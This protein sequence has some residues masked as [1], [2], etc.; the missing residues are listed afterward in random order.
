MPI[1]LKTCRLVL[2]SA[3][4]LS[5][6][7]TSVAQGGSEQTWLKP[8]PTRLRARLVTRLE[9]YVEYERERKYEQLYELFD[10]STLKSFGAKTKNDYGKSRLESDHILN[11][12]PRSVTCDTIR[13]KCEI[14]GTA[15]WQWG[16]AI[17]MRCSTLINSTLQNGE[18]YLSQGLSQSDCFPGV[19]LLTTT[20]PVL[21]KAPL[22]KKPRQRK[23]HLR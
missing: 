12:S 17:P 6:M 22:P 4:L 10:Q 1:I 13:V 7:V 3:I 15:D 9:Q 20:S 21:A 14:T 18:W 11:F 16:D 19:E 23:K 8:V 2:M 5:L